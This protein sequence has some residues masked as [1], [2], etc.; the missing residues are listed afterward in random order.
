[1]ITIHFNKNLWVGSLS[2]RSLSLKIQYFSFTNFRPQLTITENPRSKTVGKGDYCVS[3][4][5]L[6]EF[7]HISTPCEISAKLRYWTHR[8]TQKL[9]HALMYSFPMKPLCAEPP[10]VITDLLSIYLFSL[11]CHSVCCPD[12]CL[13]SRSNFSS[14][15]SLLEQLFMSPATAAHP[16]LGSWGRGGG[17]L[18]ACEGKRRLSISVE[19]YTKL[20]FRL[21]FHNYSEIH[22]CCYIEV[23]SPK[24]RV[25]Q[26]VLNSGNV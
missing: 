7:W 2:P 17:A 5:Q 18:Q 4:T 10:Q 14:S 26:N 13:T 15:F 6:N 16:D 24:L 8:L 25:E 22:S 11:Y 20:F 3:S 21:S 1:M 23:L 9:P 12:P 19:L